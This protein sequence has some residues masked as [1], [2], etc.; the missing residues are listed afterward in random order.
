MKKIL[1]SLLLVS[2]F[3]FAQNWTLFP[4]N[5][6][7]CYQSINSNVISNTIIAKPDLFITRNINISKSIYFCDT[8]VGQNNSDIYNLQSD[9]IVNH[10]IIDSDHKILLFNDIS[11]TAVLYLDKPIGFTWN[12]K[13]N[14]TA[15]ITSID[16]ANIFNTIDSIKTILLSNGDSLKVFKNYGLY[17][18]KHSALGYLKLIGDQ[19]KKLGLNIVEYNNYPKVGVNDYLNFEYYRFDGSHGF[20][21]SFNSSTLFKVRSIDKTSGITIFHGVA[22]NSSAGY[23]LCSPPIYSSGTSLD[24]NAVLYL[25]SLAFNPLP[26]SLLNYGFLSPYFDTTSFNVLTYDSIGNSIKINAFPNYNNSSLTKYFMYNIG[27]NKYTNTY[28]NHF[29]ANIETAFPYFSYKIRDF[30]NEEQSYLSGYTI[31]GQKFG[32]IDTNLILGIQLNE[33]NTFHVYPN[34]NNGLL[35]ISFVENINSNKHIQLYNQL[36][37]LVY[38]QADITVNQFE[39]NVSEFSSGVYTLKVLVGNQEQFEKVVIFKNTSQ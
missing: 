9:F 18:F 30:E 39:I 21:C 8:C 35:N 11:D 1:F 2:N 26:N 7:L 36:G 32:T 4:L 19:N 3:S 38:K 22:Y 12:F 20:P 13:A 27:P 17:L 6:T 29:E 28:V 15:A 5:D 25:D 24:L 14:I 31:K 23:T 37:E 10:Y 33:I 34:P 16:T